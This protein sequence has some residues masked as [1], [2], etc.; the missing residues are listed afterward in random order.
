MTDKE[1]KPLGRKSY[2]SIPHLPN[3]RLGPKDYCIHE[4]QALIATEKKRDKHDLIIVQ[5]KLDGTNVGVALKE[6]KLY[7]LNRAGYIANTSPYKMHHIFEDW[8]YEN[9]DRFRSVLNEGERISGEWL[10]QAH[11]TLYSLP[12]EPFVVFDIFD[13]N[14]KRLPYHLFNERINDFFVKPFLIG[15]GEPMSVEDALYALGTLG[16]HGSS[17]EVE[18]A[19]WRVERKEEVDFLCKFVR[20]S[21]EDGKYLDKFLKNHWVSNSK[22]LED[23]V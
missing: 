16:R 7:A 12:H 18:G 11:G 1:K 4:G 9:E 15:Y 5:E 3:S 20:H 8:V 14:N 2:G 21:K 19:I 13:K 10:L 22:V 17:E 23:Y 6:G